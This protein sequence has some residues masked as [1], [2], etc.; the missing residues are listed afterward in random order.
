M[1]ET[2]YVLEDGSNADPREVATDEKGVLRHSSG[3]AVAYGD[4]GNPLTR[5]VEVDEQPAREVKTE[6]GAKSK[7]KK[8]DAEDRQ[9]K[10]GDGANADPKYKTR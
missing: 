2:W 6:K 1:R 9:V 8:P 5:S 10:A 4:H 7:D 3:V